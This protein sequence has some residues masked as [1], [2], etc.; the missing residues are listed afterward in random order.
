MEFSWALQH[1]A[2]DQNGRNH[3]EN[4]HEDVNIISQVSARR[5]LSVTGNRI[6]QYIIYV[7][8]RERYFF[9]VFTNITNTIFM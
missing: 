6:Y 2:N 8:A 7:S 9:H 3:P 4:H 1:Q 5:L